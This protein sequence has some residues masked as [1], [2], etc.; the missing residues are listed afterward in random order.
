[1]STWAGE[2][3]KCRNVIMY[4]VQPMYKEITRSIAMPLT[5]IRVAKVALLARLVTTT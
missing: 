5:P 1:M 4:W 3:I 2:R